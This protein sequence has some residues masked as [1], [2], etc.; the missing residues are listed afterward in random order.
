MARA[1]G[2]ITI[3]TGCSLHTWDE[4]TTRLFFQFI[5]VHR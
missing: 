5:S 2:D 1:I 4:C 3:P